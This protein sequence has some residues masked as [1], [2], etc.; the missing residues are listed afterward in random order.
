[1]CKLTLITGWALSAKVERYVLETEV[2]TDLN[3][4]LFGYWFLLFLENPFTSPVFFSMPFSLTDSDYRTFQCRYFCLKAKKEAQCIL[5][6][7]SK[8][9]ACA[10][11]FKK[12]PICHLWGVIWVITQR[13]S[14][15]SPQRHCFQLRGGRQAAAAAKEQ[16]LC[17]SSVKFLHFA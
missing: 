13:L 4:L 3:N 2:F 14:N 17:S 8:K 9:N 12:R 11:D 15:S 16:A 10:L 7:L 1:M 5:M 6:T